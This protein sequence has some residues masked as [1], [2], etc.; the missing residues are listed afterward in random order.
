MIANTLQEQ[1]I[2]R[3][4]NFLEPQEH[5][6]LLSYVLNKEAEFSFSTIS[7]D[8]NP[9]Q[10][11]VDLTFRKSRELRSFPEIRML[12]NL[13]IQSV[14]SQVL[15]AVNLA[16]FTVNPLLEMQLTAHNHGH[17]LKLHYDNNLKN[18]QRRITYAYYFY[19]SPKSFS[20]GHL[21]IYNPKKNSHSHALLDAVIECEDIEPLDNQIVFFPSHRYH[22]VTPVI[23]P[24][25][26][27]ADS[28]FA[29]SGWI[30][31]M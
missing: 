23:C 2:F 12:I 5:L 24:T 3:I 21:K 18:L 28:R 19:R 14:L 20:G 22:E 1:K 26:Q 31:A 10:A 4:D 8:E 30:R 15:A 29:L 16:P 17:F 6:K 27:F 11:V 9:D 13:K 7:N 25:Q